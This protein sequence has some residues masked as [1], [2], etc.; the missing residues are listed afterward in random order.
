MISGI[1]CDRDKP[2][3]SAEREGQSN[4]VGVYHRIANPKSGGSLPWLSMGVPTPGYVHR[5]SPF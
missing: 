5:T 4:C 3:F 2:I 1:K